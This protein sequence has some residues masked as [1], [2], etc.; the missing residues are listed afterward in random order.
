MPPEGL[1]KIY[2][3]I[4]EVSELTEVEAHVLRFWEK[5]FPMLRPRRGRS[6]NRTYKE[7]DIEIVKEIRH[8]L[9]DQK[10]SIKLACEQLRK[11]RSQPNEEIVSQPE[12]PFADVSRDTL[13]ELR[14]D[15]VE[16]RDLLEGKGR[17]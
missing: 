5:K 10:F 11:S 14:A 12:L 17:S 9:R 7:R 4:R 13:S 15:L 3:S 1:K 6:G 2:Y 8:L 16:I